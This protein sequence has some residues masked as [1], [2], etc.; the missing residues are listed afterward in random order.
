MSS[1]IC[2]GSSAST[3]VII[4]GMHRSGTSAVASVVSSF[5]YEFGDNLISADKDNPKGFWE[6]R[7][8]VAIND[9]LLGGKSCWARVMPHE[10][11]SNE[12][13]AE[14]STWYSG[15]IAIG[16]GK[17]AFK[18]PRLCR[19]MRFWLDIVDRPKVLLVQR[20]PIAVAAS[21]QRRNAFT[22]THG[23]LLWIVYNYEAARAVADHGLQWLVIDYDRLILNPVSITEE[24]RVFLGAD[25]GEPEMIDETLRHNTE[26]ETPV[27]P[28]TLTDFSMRMYRAILVEGPSSIVSF[29][30][31]YRQILR[32]YAFVDELVNFHAHEK[33][34]W[35]EYQQHLERDLAELKL[36]LDNQ[37]KLHAH[38]KSEWSEYQQHLERDLAELKL[39]LDNQ[40]KLHAHEK[41]EWSEYQ[42]HLERDLAELKLNLDNQFKL[43]AH[44]KSEWS[45]YQQHLERDLAELKL[46]LDNQFKLHAHEKSEWSEYQQ[47]L[48]RDLAEHKVNLDSQFKLHAHEKAEWFEYRRMSEDKLAEMKG[49]LCNQVNE[50]NLVKT[51]SES[52]K[53]RLEQELADIKIRFED[54]E[55]R[56][57]AMEKVRWEVDE[58]LLE[59]YRS[60]SWRFTRPF[61]VVDDVIQSSC[62]NMIYLSKE[63][64][65]RAALRLSGLANSSQSAKAMDAL[66]E[67]R[68]SV[69]IT[70]LMRNPECEIVEW[71]EITISVVTHNNG[72]WLETFM[73][74]LLDQKYPLN[75][76]HLVFVDN[77]SSDDTPLRLTDAVK[78]HGWRFARATVEARSNK[79]F[80]AGHDF[81]IRGAS[82][83]FIL[84]SN[85]D[86]AFMVDSITR[87]VAVALHD[88]EAASWELRQ[89]PYEHPKFVDPV[90]LCVNWSSHACILLA[91]EHYLQVGGY[92]KRIF[93]YGEDVEL[94]YRLR[95][96]GH[97]L[98]YV[99]SAVVS[100]YTYK[101]AGELKPL[102]FSG[103][104]LSNYYLRL[105]YGNIKDILYAFIILSKLLARGAGFKGSRRMLL[106]VL[107]RAILMTPAF[108]MTRERTKA[109]FP[110]RS[111][112]YEI[113]RHGAFHEVIPLPQYTDELPLITVVT[114]TVAG[115]GALLRQCM[116]SVI[117]QT[118]PKIEHL[119]VEDGGNSAAELV[120][121]LARKAG[122]GYTARHIAC[123]KRG[124]SHAGNRG[125]AEADG[126]YYLLL[127]D[128]DL[129]FP[130][131]IETLYQALV[132]SKADAAYALAWDVPVD[133]IEKEA[134]RYREHNHFTA[135]LF[136]QQF[137]R[138]VLRKHNYL[139]IQAVLFSSQLFA[140]CGGFE[141]ELS[142]LEDWVLWKKY[143]FNGEFIFVPKTTSLYKTPANLLEMMHR[144][145]LFTQAY[146]LAYKWP[147]LSYPTA[148]DN[149]RADAP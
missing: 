126:K 142:H 61:R 73:V 56:Y 2:I 21:L 113:S 90:S 118:Y 3:P 51:M 110:F 50:Q 82:T 125:M 145:E 28:T 137:D 77:D 62:K 112:D 17:V 89:A 54:L 70:A 31:E 65:Y 58:L 148:T 99:P 24:I 102:Q 123:E 108:L 92:E 127:D 81:A 30:N 131:H 122:S 88:P 68:N 86:L 22:L 11:F 13:Q 133:Y 7:A 42:Q 101:E 52:V 59:A 26:A 71:P 76:I 63:F 35:S 115:R 69:D 15:L 140:R 10:E 57:V 25:G 60:R 80:G 94:S 48:E 106:S 144:R 4:L 66:V 117:N 18:D 84:V 119:V 74:S 29:E 85:I 72:H 8:L 5:G 19:L 49:F 47:H 120:A 104:I 45:E 146:E 107:P 39:N 16:E 149:V 67:M 114:R 23:I 91:R 143:A 79:G 14:A 1:S 97:L 129:L 105:R 121:D 75:K 55:Q 138:E 116:I 87:V 139:P 141:E 83:P 109:N 41:S 37:F 27:L 111:F 32:D 40:F 46:N 147:I 33:S 20:N 98:R 134:G 128:D 95:R 64:F 78:T 12:L 130:D 36:N 132:N 96:A 124:R 135:P 34:E 9:R 44:E 6:D 100:H 93:M 136:H 43:H 38:E 53:D 103:S